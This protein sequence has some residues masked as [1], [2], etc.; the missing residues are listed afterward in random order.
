MKRTTPIL[1][2]PGGKTRLLD[3]ILPLIRPHETY[4][5]A[6]GGG[7]AVFLAKERSRAEIVN[8]FSSDLVNL[9]RHAQFHMDAL[10]GEVEWTLASREDLEG[11]IEQPGLTGLQQAARYL[12]RNRLSFGGGG[13]SFAVSRRGAPSR[14]NVLEKLR[15][16]NARLDGVLVENLSYERLFRN[17]DAPGTFWF[18]D[19]PYSAGEVDVYEAWTDETMR[20]FAGRVL[21][22]KGDWVVTVNDSPLNRDLF[23]RHCVKPVQTRSGAVNKKK[24]PGAKFGEL[25]ISRKPAAKGVI[26]RTATRAVKR[27]A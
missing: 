25:I 17:Y 26:F 27:V 4:V 15:A 23:A 3:E 21:D 8:D 10:I 14:A 11:L 24:L 13:S 18:L 5:E 1:R 22:L 9:Y 16:L 2:W 12:L 7:L 6:F 20:E 19:P